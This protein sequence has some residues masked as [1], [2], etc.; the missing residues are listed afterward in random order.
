MSI[1]RT[2][3]LDQ[4]FVA[5]TWAGSLF[6]L[7]PL[8]G[9]LL[10]YLLQRGRQGDA[11]LLGVGFGGAVLIAHL[12]KVIVGRPRPDLL[13]PL[14]PMPV[15]LSFPSAHT[16]QI[17]AFCLCL[18]LIA[19]RSGAPLSCWLTSLAGGGLIV[20]VGYSRVY[21]Q[22]HY[23]SDVLAGVFIAVVWVVGLKLFLIRLSP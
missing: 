10:G 12:L 17:T 1:Y 4:F 21:L 7:L 23:L 6:V 9:G 5:I 13:P 14:V 15:G 11:W 2:P 8:V 3:L 18:L 16:A 20:A 19:C 22:V